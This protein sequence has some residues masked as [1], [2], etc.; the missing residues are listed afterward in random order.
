MFHSR[1]GC[2]LFIACKCNRCN[3]LLKESENVGLGMFVASL[4]GTHVALAPCQSR[5][6][7]S[8]RDI[9]M[10]TILPT[11]TPR[12]LRI[13]TA[14]AAQAQV[15]PTRSSPYFSPEVVEDLAQS[16]HEAWTAVCTILITIV[17]M[18]LVIGIGAVLL[19]L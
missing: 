10:T 19:T 13:R 16:D 1:I 2:E 3:E 12:E 11:R 7:L 17:T 8:P 6:D 18:G 4:L 15:L 14:P 5:N 9:Q